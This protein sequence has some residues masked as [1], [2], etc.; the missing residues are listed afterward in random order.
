MKNEP[1]VTYT[2]E[3][4]SFYILLMTDP[5]AP[6][7]QN[8]AYGEILHWLVVNI[9][10]NKIKE[11]ETKT[12]YIGAGAPKDTGLHRYIFFVFK[13]NAKQDFSHLPNV[14]KT[15]IENR[16]KSNTRF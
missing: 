1:E 10:G 16:V 5:D 7:R 14:P 9:P 8:P 11:G 13:Q 4:N 6:S 3:E 15:S 2:A 12:V